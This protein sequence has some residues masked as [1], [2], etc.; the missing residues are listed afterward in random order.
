M[1]A[2][3]TVL[4]DNIDTFGVLPTAGTAAEQKMQAVDH[5]CKG[6][7]ASCFGGG[8]PVVMQDAVIRR[9]G[10]VKV[11]RKSADRVG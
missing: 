3:G 2:F 5:P 7:E 9:E 10:L 8:A 6:V 4:H 1:R 11:A